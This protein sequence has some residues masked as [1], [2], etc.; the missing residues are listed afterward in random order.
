MV[1]KNNTPFSFD[2][3]AEAR[4]VLEEEGRKL[5][6]I[7]I[8]QWRLYLSSYT[9]KMYVR[10]RKSQRAIKLGRVI[11]LDNNTFGLE[12][13]FEND[14]VYHDSVIKK[15][16]LKGHSIMLIS[17]GWHSKKL[18]AKIGRRIERF[19]YYEGS[20]YLSKVYN[21]YMK[22]K[23]VGI[24]LDTEWSGKATKR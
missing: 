4:K 5:K 2:T 22:V 21:E 3:E 17:N 9:P 12:L 8:K 23:H 20:G 16:K 6:Y 1:S 10:T 14:L 19:T 7:A 11:K 13:T 18:E 24:T 15:S